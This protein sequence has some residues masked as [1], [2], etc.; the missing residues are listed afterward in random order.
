MTEVEPHDPMGSGVTQPASWSFGVKVWELIA[1]LR[2]RVTRL[3]PIEVSMFGG[4][5]VN[6]D[7]SSSAAT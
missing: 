4:H 5:T 3:T 2:T 1:K 7:R 6:Y